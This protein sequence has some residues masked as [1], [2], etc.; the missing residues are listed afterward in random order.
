[1]YGEI[2]IQSIISYLGAIIV[3]LFGGC[4]NIFIC[5]LIFMAI[6][7]L[8]GILKAIKNKKLSSRIGFIGI[9]K[10]CIILGI[11]CIGSLIDRVIGTENFV[12]TFVIMFYMCNEGISIL[13]NATVFNVP[14]PQK[15]KDILL[16]LNKED[17]K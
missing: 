6:D 13:E 16:E 7:Y 8:T 2:N 11:V 3:F 10:K 17:K 9:S 15:L 12:R 14:F 4:D 1:M 5:L